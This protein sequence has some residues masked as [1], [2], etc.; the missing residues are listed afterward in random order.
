MAVAQ[1]EFVAVLSKSEGRKGKM[2]AA[3]ALAAAAFVSC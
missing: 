3:A 1:Q 2:R